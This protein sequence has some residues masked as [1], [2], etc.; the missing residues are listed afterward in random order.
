MAL[1]DD[2]ASEHVISWNIDSSIIEQES[3]LFGN[4]TFVSKGV[5][6]S[7]IPELLSVEGVLD[8]L[9]HLSDSWHDEGVE[10]VGL[11]NDDVIVVSLSLVMVVMEG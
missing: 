3:I 2:L 11:E 7:L 10:V 4:S 9:V 6:N 8:L 5:G 1:S